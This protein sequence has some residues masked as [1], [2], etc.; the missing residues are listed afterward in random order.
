[1]DHN[2]DAAQLIS[3]T[4]S[5]TPRVSKG[6]DPE[7]LKEVCQQFEAI[8]IQQIYKEMRNTIPNEGYIPRGNADDMYAQLQDMEAAKITAER[9]GI[10]LAEMMMQQLMDEE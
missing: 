7:K 8:F 10:G 2:I 1:M 5:Q 3:Q 4:T 6:Q 9:G